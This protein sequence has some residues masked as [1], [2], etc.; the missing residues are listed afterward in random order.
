MS[1]EENPSKS[2]AISDIVSK[3]MDLKESNPKVL[4]GAIGAIV[5][6]ILIMMMSGGSNKS[7]PSASISNIAIGQ[8]YQLR[9]HNSV[10]SEATV[11]LVASPGS[12]AAYDDTDLKDR[13]GDCTHLAQGTKVKAVQIQTIVSIQYVN[14]EMLDGECSGRKGWVISSNLK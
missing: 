9:M 11:R 4:Y 12:L 5:V 14:V 3:I 1:N 6:L 13:S 2:S 8:T 7:L 10:D